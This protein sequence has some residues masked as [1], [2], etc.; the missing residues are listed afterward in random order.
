MLLRQI[1]ASRS[2]Q[3]RQQV[4]ARRGTIMRFFL[5]AGFPSVFGILGA[6]TFTRLALPG[7]LFFGA[8][9]LLVSL[10]A[11]RQSQ[12]AVLN[13][14]RARQ[15]AKLEELGRAL[16]LLPADDD[17]LA[18]TLRRYV[19]R[20]FDYDQADIRLFNGQVL[21]RLPQEDAPY[22]QRLWTWF[23]REAQPAAF[24]TGDRLPWSRRPST[25]NL[26]LA[27]VRHAESNEPL[28]GVCLRS[29]GRITTLGF[30]ESLPS[31]Q[32]LAAQIASMLHRRESMEKRLALERA[33]Q[34]LALARQM[35]VS[36]LP[37]ALPQI[38]GWEL[39]AELAPARQTSGDFYDLIPLGHDALGLLIA[40]VSDKG[41]S[42][43]LFMALSRTLLRTYAYD[44][45]RDPAR[46]LAAA[47][48]RI[49]SDTTDDSFVTVFYGV[50]GLQRGDLT[51]A[52]AGH[53]PAYLLSA[54]ATRAL[55]HTGMP[56]GIQRRARWDTDRVQMAPDDLLLLYT[57]GVT[58]A[59]NSDDQL[60]GVERLLHVVERRRHDPLPQVT[61]S[62]AHEVAA[63]CGP[64]PQFDD[65][66]LLL[67][68]RALVRDT[69][70]VDDLKVRE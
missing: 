69:D 38:P 59:H 20:M 18:E 27:P 17:A 32:V 47:N 37:R 45:P 36:F 29:R 70:T 6:A 51:Y 15:L 23:Q 12:A 21:L 9:V 3:D 48:G 14:Q 24:V 63:F 8:A 22:D 66:T 46:V 61:S 57:D 30:R 58:D 19:P 41:M 4:A 56:L 43:A 16:I 49:L 31:L 10:L 7:Y 1:G 11:R 53:N 35:Q 40:D 52:S 26:L 34:E 39:Q 62:I 25:E 55:D 42:A 28:G 50:L 54:G 68:R 5:L 64:R 65:L 44:Y 2:D 60:F 13:Q 33:T 67:A